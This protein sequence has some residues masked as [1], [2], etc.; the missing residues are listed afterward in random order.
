M[1]SNA[2]PVSTALI[3]TDV[4]ID[5]EVIARYTGAATIDTAERKEEDGRGWLHLLRFNDKPRSYDQLNEA[6]VAVEIHMKSRCFS[7]LLDDAGRTN[8]KLVLNPEELN[9]REFRSI[10]KW[11][12]G[13]S[14]LLI[15]GLERLSKQLKVNFA[16]DVHGGDGKRSRAKVKT[17]YNETANVYG[18]THATSP[19]KKTTTLPQRHS[20]NRGSFSEKALDAL[21]LSHKEALLSKDKTIETLS[22]ALVLKDELIHTQAALISA[23][24]KH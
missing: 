13:P 2:L 19:T 17:S 1:P 6:M 9:P 14:D 12:T 24:Q 21:N 22:N 11:P 5:P 18:G 16:S 15:P 3:S 8:G 20:N 4:E 7:S 23:L 10:K